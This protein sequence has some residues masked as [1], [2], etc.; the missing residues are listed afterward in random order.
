MTDKR[1]ST[2]VTSLVALIVVAIV[3]AIVL[4]IVRGDG[5]LLR[6]VVFSEE[7]ISP[8]ADGDTDI[9]RISY[10]ITGNATVSIY[11]VGEDGTRYYFREDETRGRGDYQVLFSGI[12]DGYQLPNEMV[13]GIILERLLQ[14]GT[15]TWVVEATPERGEM[16]QV[17]GTLTIS[18]ADV[19][20]PEMRDF[21][22]D[23]RTFSPNRD[24]IDD[25]VEP[26]FF[27]VKP[28]N[29]LRVFVEMPDG[30]E[31]PIAEKN[32]EIRFN[33]PGW[34]Y[35]DYEGGVDNGA[36]P[37]PDGT[38]VIVALAEDD[39]GQKVRVEEVLTIE[40]GGVPRA[41][42]VAPPIGDTVEFST[43]VIL[44][45]D[46]LFV[47]IIVEN[48]GDAPIRTIGP[49]PNEV[50]D[51]NWN[52]NTVGWPTESG[53]W[54]IAIGFENALND[55][56][57]RWG[58]GDPA[59][60]TEIDGHYYL[61]P[62]QRTTVTGAIRVVGEFGIRNPQP[63]WAGLIHEDVEIAQ[64]NNRVDIRDIRVE[65]PEQAENAECEVRPTPTPRPTRVEE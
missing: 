56:P 26:K 57:F 64:F 38:Y 46:T 22:L 55:Y 18:E 14:N 65:F 15:Y 58:L 19:E 11:F 21:S 34:H 5:S 43:E 36:T 20:L 60:L 28:V 63:M 10:E 13:E 53:A 1:R 61:M 29:S 54:R 35:F 32:S 40:N 47:S 23:T 17:T 45:C 48:Y 51:S 25:R 2:L 37:P 30:S 52:Y 24:G 6:N 8:N 49:W 50:Y 59:D 12:V 27:L 4:L 31:V 3:L 42:I 16:E 39:E 33:E 41:E 44:V 9:T 62:G 7:A